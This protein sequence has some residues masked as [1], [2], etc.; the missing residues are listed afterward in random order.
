MHRVLLIEDDPGIA[1]LLRLALADAGLDLDVATD[2]AQARRRFAEAPWDTILLD[3]NLPDGS[4]IDLCRE[5]RLTS[6]VPILI[7]TARRDEIDRVLGLELGADDYIVKPFSPREVAARIRA[8]LRRQEWPAEEGTAE[9]GTGVVVDTQRR[10]VRVDGAP[11]SLTRTEFQLVHTLARRPGKV[12]S[13][14]ELIEIVWEGAFLQ[15]RV[16]DS[17]VSRV[18]RKLGST[19]AGE[20][21][22]RTVHGVGYAF[23]ED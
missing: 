21:R 7:L 4:G 20:P 19:P 10:E 22:I 9:E 16:V 8:T 11:I 14:A 2:L 5:I 6:T 18:R 3:L 15:D 13:R 17:V 12:F 23:A 1:D